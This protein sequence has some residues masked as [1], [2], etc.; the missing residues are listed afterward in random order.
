MAHTSVSVLSVRIS[1]ISLEQNAP[2]KAIPFYKRN[3]AQHKL[4]FD[5]WCMALYFEYLLSRKTAELIMFLREHTVS[6]NKTMK[7]E[8]E[9]DL[10][11]FFKKLEY[12]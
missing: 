11:F 1:I 10:I 2:L 4:H 8:P 5:V 6:D 9:I 3:V 7:V 12:L